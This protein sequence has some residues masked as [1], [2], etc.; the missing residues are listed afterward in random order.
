MKNC[1]P[2]KSLKDTTRRKFLIGKQSAWGVAREQFD[3]RPIHNEATRRE[4]KPSTYT[5]WPASPISL[6]R[7]F[8]EGRLLLHAGQ[9]NNETI[10]EFEKACSSISRITLCCAQ[11]PFFKSERVTTLLSLT[12]DG[13]PFTETA[14]VSL[15]KLLGAN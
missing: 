12:L 2:E 11:T 1:I 14:R 13:R 9:L 6:A 4:K 8:R 7:E 3:R 15:I 5:D 10:P